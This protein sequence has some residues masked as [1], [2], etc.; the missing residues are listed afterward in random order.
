[1]QVLTQNK[2]MLLHVHVHVFLFFFFGSGM[3]TSL[4]DYGGTDK[5]AQESVPAHSC[6]VV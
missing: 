5:T 2:S 4:G 6:T 3:Q 1:M